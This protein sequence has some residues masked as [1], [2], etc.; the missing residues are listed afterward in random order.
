M[1]RY[2]K[3]KKNNKIN[4]QVSL[5]NQGNYKKERNN[6]LKKYCCKFLHTLLISV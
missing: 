6:S 1:R 3:N 5:F 2:Y 4:K